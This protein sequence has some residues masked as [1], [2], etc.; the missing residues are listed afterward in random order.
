MISTKLAGFPKEHLREPSL[1][2]AENC[3]FSTDRYI[4]AIMSLH[5]TPNSVF[6]TKLISHF[7]EKY[8]NLSDSSVN[9]LSYFSNFIYL[10][11]KDKVAQAVS[12]FLARKSGVWHISEAQKLSN[13]QDKFDGEFVSDEDLNEVHLLYKRLLDEEKFLE[14]FCEQKNIQ[15]LTVFYEDI[16]QDLSSSVSHILHHLNIV[17]GPNAAQ[18]EVSVNKKKLSSGLSNKIIEIYQ[19]KFPH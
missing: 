13:Y 3:N 6:G 15:P 11:R 2:L 12:L 14:K 4:K 9:P 8:L 17:E 5:V 18:L 7:I 1:I 16:V 10:V 19:S